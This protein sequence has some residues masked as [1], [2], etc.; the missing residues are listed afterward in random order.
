M[1]L[2]NALL[3]LAGVLGILAPFAAQAAQAQPRTAH[4][5]PAAQFVAEATPYQNAVIARTLR[6]SSSGTRVGPGTVEW[7]HG[8]VRLLVPRQP[9]TPTPD[10]PDL[11]ALRYSC[12][13]NATNFGGRQLEF[14]DPGYK[15]LHQYQ[16]NWT[17][18]S[19][20]I[21]Q[22]GRSWLNQSKAS[23][24]GVSRC[25]SGDSQDANYNGPAKADRW[26]LLTTNL[27]PC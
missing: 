3:V 19:Y 7:S 15:D 4:L 23:N 13:Y 25:M 16:S 18:R 6:Y 27:S 10:C 14:K 24:H 21:E 26:L 22:P 2:R 5:S 11:L 20:A 12:V 17:T 8:S 9:N 1:R